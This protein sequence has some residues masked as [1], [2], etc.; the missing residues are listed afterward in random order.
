MQKDEFVSTPEYRKVRTAVE[1]LI[2]DKIAD[3]TS[4]YSREV[5]RLFLEWLPAEDREFLLASEGLG[6]SQKAEVAWLDMKG[7]PYTQV[8]VDVDTWLSN[9]GTPR[10]V[11]QGGGSSV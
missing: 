11:A 6:N 1:R 8:E 4:Q 5:H 2:S 9:P 3:S 10:S 7:Y